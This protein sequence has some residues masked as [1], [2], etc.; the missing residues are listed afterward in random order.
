MTTSSIWSILDIEATDDASTIRRAYARRVKIVHPED[1]PEGFKALRNAYS[2]AL[3]WAARPTASVIVHATTPEAAEMSPEEA[4][5][6]LDETADDTL[7]SLTPRDPGRVLSLDADADE[8]E[9]QDMAPPAPDLARVRR[10]EAN[11]SEPPPATSV[12]RA[13]IRTLEG[14]DDTPPPPTVQRDYKAA[15]AHLEGLL[16]AEAEPESGALL[17]DVDDALAQSGLISAHMEIEYRLGHLAAHYWPRSDPFVARIVAHFRWADARIDDPHLQ[18]AVSWCVQ[19]DKDL[20]FLAEAQKRGSPLLRFAP[21]LQLLRAAPE[22]RKP[23]SFAFLKGF[24]QPG[25]LGEVR[26]LLSEIRAH[27]TLEAEFPAPAQKAWWRYF[28]NQRINPLGLWIAIT[29]VGAILGL[30]AIPQV[31]AHPPNPAVVSIGALN[32][33]AT[34]GDRQSLWIVCQAHSEFAFE[35]CTAPF[36]PPAGVTKAQQELAVQTTSGTEIPS[37][38]D[39]A[40]YPDGTNVAVQI[41]V[42]HLV[43]PLPPGTATPQ[44]PV[45]ATSPPTQL[46][47]HPVV[48][49]MDCHTGSRRSPCRIVG[50]G[51]NSHRINAKA[52]DALERAERSADRA[53]H[54]R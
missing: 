26:K 50:H 53:V 33:V 36:A 24:I 3:A 17:R 51:A 9:E 25:L 37:S 10:L 49:V 47:V 6:T 40:G 11:E 38:I 28:N 15:L 8:N 18:Q 54:P 27:P 19:R 52:L 2:Q 32:D 46:P 22:L 13:S 4:V 31:A 45:E 1:D 21:Q 23:P 29:V 35:N 12:E 30:S 42:S 44:T 39:M 48:V 43:A 5:V 41:D 14:A 7:R 20:V 34:M 16:A